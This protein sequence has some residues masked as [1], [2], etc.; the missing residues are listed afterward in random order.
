MN[1]TFTT[2]TRNRIKA[3]PFHMLRTSKETHS[4]LHPMNKLVLIKTIFCLFSP[5]IYVLIKSSKFIKVVVP[6]MLNRNVD[7]YYKWNNILLG[8]QTF[9]MNKISLI[10]KLLSKATTQNKRK[11]YRTAVWFSWKSWLLSRVLGH[12]LYIGQEMSL[13][14]LLLRFHL[15]TTHILQSYHQDY[16]N[17]EYKMVH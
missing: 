17:L 12:Y 13:Q 7:R 8:C 6:S 3:Y 1:D 9:P 11:V 2:K 15:D 5:F 10:C 16:R 4:I 14:F